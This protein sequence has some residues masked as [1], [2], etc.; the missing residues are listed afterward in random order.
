[1]KRIVGL[2]LLS[3]AMVGALSSALTLPS[4]RTHRTP[5]SS[6]VQE[7]S[8]PTEESSDCQLC[9][10]ISQLRIGGAARI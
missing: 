4:L 10:R 9:L 3:L 8:T 2:W 1:M 5:R 7:T 6:S